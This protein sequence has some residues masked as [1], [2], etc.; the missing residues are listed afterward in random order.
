M[1]LVPVLAGALAL[2]LAAGAGAATTQ[3][4]E[5]SAGS[6]GPLARLLVILCGPAANLLAFDVLDAGEVAALFDLAT[7]EPLRGAEP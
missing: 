3:L 5:L 4:G 2:M 1:R 6:L 7:P